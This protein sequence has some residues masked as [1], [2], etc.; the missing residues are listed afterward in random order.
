MKL[1]VDDLRVLGAC[2]EAICYLSRK[3]PDGIELTM[4]N[5]LKHSQQLMLHCQWI[6]IK[7]EFKYDEHTRLSQYSSQAYYHSFD[8]EVRRRWTD[9]AGVEVLRALKILKRRAAFMRAQRRRACFG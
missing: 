7:A 6:A 2:H 8:P 1:T 5:V 9:T 4:E 3:E